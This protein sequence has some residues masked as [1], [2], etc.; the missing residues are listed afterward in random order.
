MARMSNYPGFFHFGRE[1]AAMLGQK[2][3]RREGE[4]P[5]GGLRN[6]KVGLELIAKGEFHYARFG[7]E[8]GVVHK[9]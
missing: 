8:P 7:G 9:C 6:R 4:L 2:R 5:G 1:S 3:S